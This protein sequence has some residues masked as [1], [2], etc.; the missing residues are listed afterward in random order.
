MN[1]MLTFG[2]HIMKTPIKR[3][4]LECFFKCYLV[5]LSTAKIT[6]HQC[7]INEND[8]GSEKNLFQCHFIPQKL[9]V[10][11]HGTEHR[12]VFVIH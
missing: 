3:Y 11:C 12:P 5:M 6:Q 1:L 9:H 10:D 2:F 4:S 7:R 8:T